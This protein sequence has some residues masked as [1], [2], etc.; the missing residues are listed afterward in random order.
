MWPHLLSILFNSFVIEAYPVFT[1][2]STPSP[3]ENAPS[4]AYLVIDVQL[5]ENFI[6]CSS[7]KQARFDG[8]GFFTV[9]GK[10]S[11]EWLEM[12]LSLSPKKQN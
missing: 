8:V 12:E 3:E 6:L 1:F 9:Q 5:P 2:E 11:Q 4:Y 7:I 10:D